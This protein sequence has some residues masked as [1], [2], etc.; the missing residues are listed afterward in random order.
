MSRHRDAR[1]DRSDRSDRSTAAAPTRMYGPRSGGRVDASPDSG[2]VAFAPCIGGNTRSP[3][4]DPVPA[5]G[6]TTSATDSPNASRIASSLATWPLGSICVSFCATRRVAPEGALAR[7]GAL[8]SIPPPAAGG[9]PATGGAPAAGS[10]AAFTWTF[11]EYD[12]S[13]AAASVGAIGLIGPWPPSARPSARVVGG[14]A[15]TDG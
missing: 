6:G 14:P 7:V 11:G 12:T 15:M 2:P 4:F 13:P 10:G 1:R 8:R 5:R 9:P 3:G